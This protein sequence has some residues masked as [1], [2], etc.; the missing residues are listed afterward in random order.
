MQIELVAIGDE[1]LRGT[2][3]NTNAAFLSRYLSEKGYQIS[4]HTT[5]SDDPVVLKEALQE[6]RKRASIVITTG[7]LGPTCDDRTREILAR[8]FSSEFHFN[9]SVAADLKKRF[10]DKLAS[11]EDQAT[12]PAKAKPIL[13][14]VGTAPGLIF[15]EDEK[16]WIILPGVPQEMHEMFL[17]DALPY[18]L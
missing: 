6:I 18:L 7:G 17:N 13:N 15:T 2:T 14:R 11:L 10:G 16:T 3:V 1:L 4:R 9:Q 5:L 8:L 12:I